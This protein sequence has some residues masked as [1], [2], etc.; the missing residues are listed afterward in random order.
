MIF[1]DQNFDKEK[2]IAIENSKK[3]A[4]CLKIFMSL[5]EK[6]FKIPKKNSIEAI[7]CIDKDI[8]RISYANRKRIFTYNL[9]K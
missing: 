7:S 6:D 8:Q 4:K 3:K 1:A 2:Y 5:L 9:K